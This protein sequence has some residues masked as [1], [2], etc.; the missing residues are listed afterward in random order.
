MLS[1]KLLNRIHCI[2]C[3]SDLAIEDND[4]LCCKSCQ[5]F[6]SSKN[7]IPQLVECIPVEEQDWN[8]WNTDEIIKTGDSYKKRATGELPEKEASK[9]FCNVLKSKNLYFSGDS[10]LDIGSAC[11]HFYY[12]FFNRLDKNID[13]TG[14]DATYKFLEWGKEIYKEYPNPS[15]VLGDALNLPFK[16]NS[17]DTVIV[18]L[19]HFFPNLMDALS[20]AIRVSKKRV[21][22][23]TPI[24]SYNYSIKMISEN[25]FES[26][27]AITP[28]RSDYN[29]TLLMMYT[30]EYLYGLVKSLNSK[31]EFIERDLDF[32]DFDNNELSDFSMKSTRVVN[33]VQHH[34]NIILDWH[35][36][37]IVPNDI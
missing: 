6:Y 36:V 28:D 26:M 11:G 35:Y 10:I 18:N 23:R 7:D 32:A 24:G 21:L 33:G 25:D 16:K 19:Y 1:N 12:S 2:K 29:H 31:I 8:E 20:E 30:K 9:S 5:S 27:G 17:F 3:F 34:G 4:T 37:S 15:F 13:Y 22:W 14:I